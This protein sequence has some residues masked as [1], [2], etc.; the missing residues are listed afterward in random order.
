MERVNCSKH[1]MTRVFRHKSSAGL[2]SILTS[3]K[4]GRVFPKRSATRPNA[5]NTV[6][7]QKADEDL[8][9]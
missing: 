9:G 4:I 2:P 5:I 6:S 1:G 3:A 7:L 8:I